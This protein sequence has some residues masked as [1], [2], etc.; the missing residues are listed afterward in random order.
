M[1]A[2]ASQ[3]TSLTIDYSTVYLSLDKRK[4]Q[5]SASQAFVRGIYRGP[6]NFWNGYV[7]VFIAATLM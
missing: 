7:V 5:S 2:I 3:I 4:H 1:E 6:V